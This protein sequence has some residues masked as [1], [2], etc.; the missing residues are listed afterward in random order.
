MSCGKVAPKKVG[1][2]EGQGHKRRRLRR[3]RPPV[4]CTWRQY[5]ELEPGPRKCIKHPAW[6]S[7]AEWFGALAT[8]AGSAAAGPG[9]VLVG[10]LPSVDRRRRR[11]GG[12]TC[13][14]VSDPAAALRECTVAADAGHE[15]GVGSRGEIPHFPG[16]RDDFCHFGANR[17]KSCRSGAVLRPFIPPSRPGGHPALESRAL[18]NLAS[19]AAVFAARP[20]PIGVAT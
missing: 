5:L 8:A 11:A 15:G 17:R 18:A 19:T 14:T 1:S 7:S 12:C 2:L 4:L 9:R 6:S 13:R 20:G 10:W 3:P 16:K